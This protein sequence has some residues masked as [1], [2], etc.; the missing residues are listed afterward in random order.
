MSGKLFKKSVVSTLFIII[1]GVLLVFTIAQI[2]AKTA[3][4]NFLERKLPQHVQ[5]HYGGMHASVI[6]G[7]I[8]LQEIS[9]DFYDRDSM[10]LNARVKMDDL[11][12]VGLGYWNFLVNN[13]ISVERLH[14]ERPQVWYYPYRILPKKNSEPEGVVKL[15]KEIFIDE[16]VV[17]DGSL[18]VLRDGADSTAV[19]LKK[20]NVSIEN[21]G[22]G[23]QQIVK[24]I[25]VEYGN[26][27]L[28]ANS[29]FVNLGSYEKLDV[30][31]LLWNQK[32]A[33]INGLQLHSKYDRNLLSQ[34]LTEERDYIDLQVSMMRLDS[35]R[36][37][38]E[39][40]TF[41][42]ET[43]KGTI[44]KPTLEL[45]RD[46][47]VADGD[48]YKKL[49]GRNIRE[50]P[51]YLNVPEI[52]ITDG[53]V[54]YSERVADIKDPGKLTFELLNANLSNISNTYPEG[55][56]TVIKANTKFMGSADMSLNWSFDVNRINDAFY[57]SGTVFNFNTESINPFLR[58]NARANAS[59][60]I[61]ELYFTIDGNATASSGD[62]KM[63]YQNFKFQVL[64]K[65]RSGINKLLTAIGNIFVNDGSSADAQG[66]R[67]GDIKA[68]R[69]P[70][71]S[72]FSYLWLNVRNG[73]LS[74]LTGNGEK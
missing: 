29:L 66:Y 5:L 47:L 12:L 70:T 18:N 54:V 37:G 72:F 53:T 60:T 63:K 74:T 44:N 36:F 33:E 28:G 17:Q 50:L 3:V 42:I 1:V 24:K 62:M 71:K 73:T 58:S 35:I 56:T 8:G 38:F 27:E 16:L 19:A 15:L 39:R 13:T 69:D 52:N 4:A 7:T 49:Y 57:A 40:D 55:E 11:S 26:Y 6:N 59:G 51:I 46:K 14:L 22:T 10:V 68:E 32:G 9:L 31:S 64:K 20:I 43:G 23:P 61:D 21:V 30:E 34:H 2:S 41:F 48:T 45:F 65:D 67:Y 25:P